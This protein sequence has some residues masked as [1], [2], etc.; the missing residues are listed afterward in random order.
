MEK[1][2]TAQEVAKIYNVEHRTMLGWLRDGKI[3]AKRIGKKWAITKQALEDFEKKE[4][5]R[6]G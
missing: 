3:K 2:F 6:Q 4:D 5:P 1:Y